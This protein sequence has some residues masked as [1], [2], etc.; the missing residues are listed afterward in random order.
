MIVYVTKRY[1]DYTLNDRFLDYWRPDLRAMVRLE[2]YEN[3]LHAKKLPLCTYIFTDIERL[4]PFEQEAAARIHASLEAS[5]PGGLRINHPLK[6]KRRF[7][8][9]QTLHEAGLNDFGVYRAG[10]NPRPAR[11][12]VFVRD[13]NDHDGPTSPLID[14]Q[15]ALDRWLAA[16]L[17]DGQSL[18]GWMVIEYQ[19]TRKDGGPFIKYGG[20]CVNGRIM[21][22]HVLFDDQWV[23]KFGAGQAGDPGRVAF[24]YDYV[25]NQPHREQIAR[26]FE[27]AN[28]EYGRI[29]YGV[30]DGRVQTFEINTNPSVVPSP[31]LGD[32]REPT[33]ERFVE[34]Y[35]EALI[36]LDSP[37]RGHVA[38]EPSV[39][40]AYDALREVYRVYG[41]KVGWFAARKAVR[42]R[43]GRGR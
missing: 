32:A 22:Q 29:D 2:T 23:V 33:R 36:A 34:H 30:V 31:R 10:D 25:Q 35:S 37:V 7:A 6:S 43:F 1:H 9:L 19:E 28:I 4:S 42:K 13:A 16:R 24:E 3:L 18:S 40:P 12:P 11:F 21:T 8:L 14:D 15:D 38:V 27:L 20:Y 41:E 39:R 5:D 17:D 26:I